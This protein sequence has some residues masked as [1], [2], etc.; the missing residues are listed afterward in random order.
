VPWRF[1]VPIPNGARQINLV[2]TDAG[3][4]SILN[5]GDWIEA[6]FVT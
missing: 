2:V 1:N 4:R 3:H 6:G 5:Y